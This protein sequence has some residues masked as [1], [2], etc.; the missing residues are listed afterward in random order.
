MKNKILLG[1]TAFLVVIQFIRPSKNK[2]NIY[3][4]NHISKQY[5]LPPGV[6]ASFKKACY[7]CHSNNTNYPWYNNIQPVAFFIANHVNHGMKHLNFSEFTT[8]PDDKKHHKLEEIRE[9]IEEGWMPM[10]SY[11]LLHK[12][13][14]LT[15]AEKNEIIEWTKDLQKS[16]NIISENQNDTK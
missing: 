11:E 14:I 3:G 15:Q 2:G 1:L 13:A 6:D 5:G 12:D 4:P 10:R 7:D 16:I 8:L 9:S